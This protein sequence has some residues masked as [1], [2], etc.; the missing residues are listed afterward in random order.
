MSNQQIKA[1][2]RGALSPFW[3]LVQMMLIDD[4]DLPEDQMAYAKLLQDE[5]E[6]CRDKKEKIIQLID[7]IKD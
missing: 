3:N 6:R 4:E 7:S 2:L 5:A 1:D